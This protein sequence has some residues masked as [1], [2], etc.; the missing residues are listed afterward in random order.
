MI[1]IGWRKDRTLA[2]LN[3]GLVS[4][5]SAPQVLWIEE[6]LATPVEEWK[7]KFDALRTN[8][9]QTHR[10]YVRWIIPEGLNSESRDKLRKFQCLL[11]EIPR[12]R[13]CNSPNSNASNGSKF[14]HILKFAQFAS[15]FRVRVPRSVISNNPAE[16][17][18]AATSE[19]PHVLKGASALKSICSELLPEHLDKAAS[20]TRVVYLL[21]ERVFG[22]DVRVH[23]TSKEYVA[24]LA[25]SN[26]VDYRFA[27]QK[28]FSQV[29]L[30]ADVLHFSLECLISEGLQFA[31]LDF[32]VSQD[33]VWYFLEVNGSPAFQGYDRRSNGRILQML[34]DWL[35]AQ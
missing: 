14:V 7:A 16:L 6:L 33:G 3:A 25:V 26:E 31:G 32:K 28:K 17:Q 2:Y 34:R 35:D 13:I 4:L 12:D 18:S 11:N 20:A 5:G 27:K 10:I 30:P 23:L 24:E 21:Q 29:Q 9:E 22:P 1:L 8:R 15:R 19:I